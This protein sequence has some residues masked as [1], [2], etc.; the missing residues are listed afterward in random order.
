MHYIS[1][2]VSYCKQPLGVEFGDLQPFKTD[3]ELL[4]SAALR[5]S[6]QTASLGLFDH[7][8]LGNLTGPKL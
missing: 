8:L 3:L 5:Q 4:L 1:V 6:E 7:Q 2:I